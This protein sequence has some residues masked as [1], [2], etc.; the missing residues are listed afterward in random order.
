MTNGHHFSPQTDKLLEGFQI[1]MHQTEQFLM[2]NGSRFGECEPSAAGMCVFSGFLV[3]VCALLESQSMGAAQDQATNARLDEFHAILIGVMFNRLQ[4]Q[5]PPQ[6]SP[7][8]FEK[9]FEIQSKL[10]IERV[11]AERYPGY[12]KCFNEDIVEM[13]EGPS[14]RFPRLAE[15]FMQDVVGTP[16][17]FPHSDDFSPGSFIE[18][19]AIRLRSHFDGLFRLG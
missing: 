1:S 10:A 6:D 9:E 17:H 18:E 13:A 7:E 15:A 14:A 8:P 4:F 19:T 12:F 11:F 3:T 16:L 2:M 5:A